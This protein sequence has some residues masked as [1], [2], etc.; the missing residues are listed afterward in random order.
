[1][2]RI[3][4]ILFLTLLFM[5]PSEAR[6]KRALVIGIG[7]QAD[8]SWSTIHGDRDIPIISS[9][10][11]SCGFSDITT[12]KN[13]E[14]TKAAIVG[15]IKDLTSRCK[16][17]DIVYIHFSG[18]GQR[19]TD[20]D[21][22][23]VDDGYDEAWI[24][25]DAYRRYCNN[26]KGEKHLSDDELAVL[27]TAMRTKIG[28][29]GNIVVVVDA[30]HS[31]DST[32]GSD[33]EDTIFVRGVR[34]TFEIPCKTR[35]SAQTHDEQWLTLSACKAYQLNQ[36]HRNG[37]GK[38]SYAIYTLYSGMSEMT[39]DRIISAVNQY[40]QRPDVS[41]GHMTQTPVLTG[42]RQKYLFNSIFK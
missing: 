13:E 38:L 12:L 10:L 23:E 30:C 15:R 33:D 32:R 22:D 4:I 37:Y 20:V 1:M 9:M 40:M 7:K 5:S 27:L 28:T 8:T 6:N 3:T 18:H 2:K 39:N 11:R 19:M 35:G 41:E 25:Y 26:D 16:S 34:D 36:E 29:E 17:S 14:A 21:G 24:P 42:D 31:G